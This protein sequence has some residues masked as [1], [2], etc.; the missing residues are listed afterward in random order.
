QP[1]TRFSS[2]SGTT[3]FE[4]KLTGAGFE[5]RAGFDGWY[6]GI[7]LSANLGATS[8]LS[9]QGYVYDGRVGVRVPF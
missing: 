5:L 1:E 4:S 8:S 3:P 7:A 2:A 6:S 9:G